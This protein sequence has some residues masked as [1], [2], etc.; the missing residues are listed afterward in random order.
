MFYRLLTIYTAGNNHH[1]KFSEQTYSQDLYFVDINYYSE[2]VHI[3]QIVS[4]TILHDG[5][6]TFSCLGCA[7]SGGILKR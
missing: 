2:H 1:T 7:K 4:N 5:I 3:E 6:D